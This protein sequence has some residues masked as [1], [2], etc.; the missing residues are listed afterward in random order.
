MSISAQG[1]EAIQSQVVF[2]GPHNVIKSGV[3]KAR[4]VLLPKNHLPVLHFSLL[5]L[6]SLRSGVDVTGSG[7]QAWHAQGLF[8]ALLGGG[9]AML[10]IEQGLAT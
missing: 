2:V 8:L 4:Q 5:V 10:G 3:Y 9:T 6:H 7:G 1:S